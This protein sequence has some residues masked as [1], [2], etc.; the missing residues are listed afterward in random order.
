[1]KDVSA[2]FEVTAADTDVGGVTSPHTATKMAKKCTTQG[3]TPILMNGGTMT[4]AVTMYVGAGGSPMPSI[5]PKK[6]ATTTMAVKFTPA[7][8]IS[9]EPTFVGTPVMTSAPVMIDSVAR[10]SVRSAVISAK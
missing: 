7:A 3:S 5:A 10:S 2:I 6:K 9:R 1:M 8:A 4:S